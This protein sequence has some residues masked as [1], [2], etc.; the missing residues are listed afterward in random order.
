MNYPKFIR[1]RGRSKILGGSGT[2]RRNQVLHF[3]VSAIIKTQNFLQSWWRCSE[4]NLSNPSFWSILDNQNPKFFSTLVKLFREHFKSA[5]SKISS[6]MVKMFGNNP[7]K[8]FF[9]IFWEKTFNKTFIL[10]HFKSS[11][12]ESDLPSC[13]FRTSSQS[14][15]L[16]CRAAA[17]LFRANS[18]NF[19]Q[20]PP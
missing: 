8:L 3:R 4:I 9:E 11:K 10:E 18:I 16:F 14:N 19:S 2:S 13:I 15:K 7:S 20:P 5:K 6:T 17:P 12:Y 1:V